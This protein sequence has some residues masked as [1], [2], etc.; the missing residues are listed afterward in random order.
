MQFPTDIKV[1]GS[2]TT[3]LNKVTLP[4]NKKKTIKK[5]GTLNVPPFL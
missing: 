5:D 4:V 2:D 1:Q 3:M